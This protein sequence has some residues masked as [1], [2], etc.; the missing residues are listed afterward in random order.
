MI[1]K[2]NDG[3]LWITKKAANGVNRWIKYKGKLPPQSQ[4]PKPSQQSSKP[5][6]QSPTQS[7]HLNTAIHCKTV[8][9]YT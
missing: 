6:Q 4:R 7:D 1:K 2:G 8:N 5:S 9:S 3:N